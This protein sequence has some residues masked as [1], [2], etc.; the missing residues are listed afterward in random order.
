MHWNSLLIHFVLLAQV[1]GVSNPLDGSINE[2]EQ[3]P[4]S[5][6]EWVEELLTAPPEGAL[7]GTPVTLSASLKGIRG[8]RQQLEVI[9]AYWRLSK[10]MAEYYVAANVYRVIRADTAQTRQSAPGESIQKLATLRLDAARTRITAIEAQADLAALIRWTGDT[11]PLPASHPH[12]GAYHTRYR[13]IFANQPNRQARRLHHLLPNEVELIHAHAEM[14]NA[15]ASGPKNQVADAT[16][17]R[18]ECGQFLSSIDRYNR[19][20]ARYVLLA[21]DEDSDGSDIVPMLIKV[22]REEMD[23]SRVA[24][25]PKNHQTTT[26]PYLGDSTRVESSGKQSNVVPARA[27]E[28]L[29]VQGDVE[30]SV[31]VRPESQKMDQPQLDSNSKAFIRP[32]EDRQDSGDPGWRSQGT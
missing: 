12:V 13:E 4:M 2:R 11:L 27:E 30:H 24:N 1:P 15:F 31:L 18:E 7:P 20:I 23:N 26:N 16:R 21:S 19:N 5:A 22:S 14:L 17:F 25:E 6:K 9:D 8:D 29:P 28:E 10:A 32:T 3:Q